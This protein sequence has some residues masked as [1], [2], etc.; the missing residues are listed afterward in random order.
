[1]AG[2]IGRTPTPLQF[3]VSRT[4]ASSIARTCPCT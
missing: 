1:M 4:M 2:I 3:P